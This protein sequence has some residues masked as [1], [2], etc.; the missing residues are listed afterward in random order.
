MFPLFCVLGVNTL[1]RQAP[2]TDRLTARPPIVARSQSD[3]SYLTNSQ[4]MRSPNYPLPAAQSCIVNSTEPVVQSIHSRTLRPSAAQSLTALNQQ[5]VS[6]T[7]QMPALHVSASVRRSHS[8]TTVPPQQP[9][10]I[11]RG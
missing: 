4:Q 2:S 8:F 6:Q 9:Q 11:L 7:R 3:R 5:P 10:N 1:I